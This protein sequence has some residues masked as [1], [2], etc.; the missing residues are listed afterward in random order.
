MSNALTA[1]VAV[2][3]LY[4]LQLM[5]SCD[6]HAARP[7]A[8]I[9]FSD[10]SFLLLPTLDHVIDDQVLLHIDKLIVSQSDGVPWV[11]VCDALARCL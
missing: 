7:Q 3:D 4:E 6:L 8:Q 11:R 5:V 1:T 2:S 9:W 10:C